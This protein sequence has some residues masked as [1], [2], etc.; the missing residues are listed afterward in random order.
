MTAFPFDI[1]KCK[2]KFGAW[3][4]AGNLVDLKVLIGETGYDEGLIDMT[5]YVK[6]NSWEVLK[7]CIYYVISISSFE[8]V[9][10]ILFIAQ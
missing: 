8:M 1:Q 7:V 3:T 4:H 9:F 6:S 10:E 5:E 2:L